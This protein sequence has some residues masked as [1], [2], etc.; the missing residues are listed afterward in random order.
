L[1]CILLFALHTLNTAKLRVKNLISSIQNFIT[2][3]KNYALIILFFTL[4]SSI[5]T[6]QNSINISKIEGSFCAGTD[7]SVSYTT[8]GTFN[9]GNK[10]KIQYKNNAKN[11]WIDLKTEG[12]ESPLKVTLPTFFDQPQSFSNLIFDFRVVSSNPI[13]EGRTYDYVFLKEF[14]K[15]D[16]TAKEIDGFDIDEAVKVS[17][18]SS[19]YYPITLVM[20]DSSV[21]TL[22]NQ[23]DISWVPEKSGEYFI[24]RASNQC[25]IGTSSGKVNIIINSVGIKIAN[26]F[27]L[28]VC[29][30]GVINASYN[31]NGI[32]DKGNKFKIRLTNKNSSNIIYEF[33]ATEKDGVIS[34]NIGNNVTPNLYNVSI[35]GTN[36]KFVSA[37]SLDGIIVTFAPSAEIITESSNISFGQKKFMNVQFRGVGPFYAKINDGTIVSQTTSDAGSFNTDFEIRPLKT[38]Q[39]FIE[40]FSSGCGGG[41]G[42]TKTTITVNQGIKTDSLPNKTTYCAGQT[43]KIPFSSN[44]KLDASS[45]FSVRFSTG[46][47]EDYEPSYV[48]VDAKFVTE[49]IVQCV[50]PKLVLEKNNSTSYY[51]KVFTPTIKGFYSP[52]QITFYDNPS[53]NFSNLSIDT[54]KSP[55]DVDIYIR[56]QG[57]GISN[58]TLND[59]LS[60]DL[61]P[62]NTF[63]T[64]HP[65]SLRIN[66]TNSFKIS[67]VANSCGTTK[68]SSNDRKT[69]IISN[70]ILQNISLKK[71]PNPSYCVGSKAQVEFST[72]GVFDSNNE[73]TVE[74]IS[75]SN[76]MVTALGKT[77][78]SSME[79]T[80]PTT[81]DAGNYKIRVLSSNPVV[82]SNSSNI[83]LQTIPSLTYSIMSFPNSNLLPIV[84][85]KYLESYTFL[86]GGIYE[87]ETVNGTVKKEGNVLQRDSYLSK[88]DILKTNDLFGVKSVKNSCGI[89]KV[90]ISN[91]FVKPDPYRLSLSYAGATLCQSS[92][93]NLA[94]SKTGNLPASLSYSVQIAKANDTTFTTLQTNLTSSIATFII[95]SSYQSGT[96]KI[97][98]VSEDGLSIKSNVLFPNYLRV[99]STTFTTIDGKNEGVIDGETQGTY[100]LFKNVEAGANNYVLSTDKNQRFSYSFFGGTNAAFD[101]K[102]KQT[103]V[104]TL[105]TVSNVCGYGTGSGSVKIIV[106]PNIR[107]TFNSVKTS[108]LSTFCVGEEVNINFTTQGTFEKD[109]KFKISV[110]ADTL[111]KKEVFSTS[112]EGV[113]KVKIP[114]NIEAG[115]YQ[116]EFSSTNPIL[117]KTIQYITINSVPEVVLSG[118]GAII[119]IGDRVGLIMNVN[120]SQK[121]PTN[122]NIQYK[123]SDSTSSTLNLQGRNLVL[124]QPINT[125]KTFTLLSAQNACGVGKVSGSAKITVNPASVKQVNFDNYALGSSYFCRGKEINVAFTTKGL[126]TANNKFVAQLSDNNG[127]NY[128]D[129][130]TTGTA[131]PLKAIIPLITP[132]GG[133][134]RLRVVATDNDATSTTNL[135]ALDIRNELTARFDTAVYNFEPNKSVTIKLRFVGDA[136]YTVIIGSDEI[137]AKTISATTNPYSLVVNPASSVIYKLFSVSNNQCGTG[138]V[139]AQNTVTLQLIT[140]IEELQ[141][142]GINIFPNPTIEILKIETD[143]KK[144]DLM[145]FDITGKMILEKSLNSSKDELN[146]QNFPTGQYLL[147]V[148]KNGKSASFKVI[149][150]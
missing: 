93:T 136:P 7:I 103:T 55:Q 37:K 30:N 35:V 68:I 130:V 49:G 122:E 27:P 41:V 120:P 145:F 141:E 118:G 34:A 32:L 53:A 92:A 95:P 44:V 19:G 65:L 36:P 63:E 26:V 140:A 114:S 43:I 11:L 137:T 69:V 56:T 131:S 101:V 71:I 1:F 133:G 132:V 123:L 139:L 146:L 97:R 70:P 18:V 3:L 149:K 109:N 82:I 115:N 126:F 57:A 142:M 84:G 106:K 23:S 67:S 76:S 72:L 90:F 88:I 143:G 25:G 64:Y 86:G 135:Y 38:N 24:V 40:S 110:F 89:G 91:N 45:K 17:N 51:L 66:N 121:V 33:D 83:F 85:E 4:F 9:A 77:K 134:Y 10:F 75:Q 98:I 8:Q 124:T 148:Q 128:K 31:T 102:P 59:S 62:Y 29:A 117:K 111:D 47:N 119:N 42:V 20:N 94:V 80:L 78:S 16:I 79:V 125:S 96:Y 105:K 138:T 112:V 21:V 52:H 28:S 6:A 74:L 87:Y 39:Y 113:F 81:N 54:Y 2:M 129:L 116:L 58:I 15:V 50:L 107:G 12:T 144:T 108:S 14:P 5:S 48:D 61:L 100:L 150:H 104:Y 13:F 99:P 46:N 127:E 22:T 73:F 147:R 60:F